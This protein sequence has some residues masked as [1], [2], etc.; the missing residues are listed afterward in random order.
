[1]TIKLLVMKGRDR[2]CFYWAQNVLSDPEGKPCPWRQRSGC[3]HVLLQLFFQQ[4]FSHVIFQHCKSDVLKVWIMSAFKEQISS[5][6]EIMVTASVTE[7]TKVMADMSDMSDSSAPQ[8]PAVTENTHDTS[9]Q[10]VCWM[11]YVWKMSV[12]L[13]KQLDPVCLPS[14]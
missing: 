5:I 3:F 8:V 2:S 6:L 14:F 12:L 11:P 4:Y 7:I 9:K 1:M 10:K 13:T